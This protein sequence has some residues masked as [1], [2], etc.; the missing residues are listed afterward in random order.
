MK[1]RRILVFGDAFGVP[2][3]LSHLQSGVVGIVGA[4]TRPDSLATIGRVASE[5]NLP[6]YVQPAADNPAYRSFRQA[7]ADA[8]PNLILVNSYAMILKPD[9]LDLVQYHAFNVHWALLPRHRGPN[10]L[11]WALIHGDPKTGVTLHCIEQGLD[12]GDIV[13]QVAVEIRQSDSWATL[14]DR[15]IVAA[16]DLLARTLPDILLGKIK[17]H[18][19][20]P[21]IATTNSRLT[22]ESPRIDPATMNDEQIFNLIRAQIAPLP[23]AYF[24]AGAHIERFDRYI[25]LAEIPSLRARLLETVSGSPLPAVKWEAR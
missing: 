2:Q 18:P 25:P 5:R 12:S 13:A 15:V 14:R 4:S 1:P 10:P 22:P 6:L 7:V 16:D 19:Q 3:L 11:Q 23:G 20:D 17:R 8:A 9:L 24:Q 21:S